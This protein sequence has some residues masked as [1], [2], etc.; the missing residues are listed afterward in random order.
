[1]T[2][3]TSL[4]S[5]LSHTSVPGAGAGKCVRK[6]RRMLEF[7]VAVPG[8]GL[9]DSPA[10]RTQSTAE[11]QLQGAGADQ[12]PSCSTE[13]TGT[14]PWSLLVRWQTEQSLTGPG[15]PK[16]GGNPGGGRPALHPSSLPAEW[17]GGSWQACTAAVPVT[18]SGPRSGWPTPGVHWVPA[19]D[20][21][22]SLTM[23]VLP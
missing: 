11:K 21:A 17:P 14:R 22:N 20:G 9:G 3:M 10:P 1:M 6:P 2:E 5:S 13:L 18:A 19:H 8:E 7:P 4:L 23:R 12:P 16:E 15:F